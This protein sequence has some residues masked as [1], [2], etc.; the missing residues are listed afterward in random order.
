MDLFFVFF[1]FPTQCYQCD[2]VKGS[3]LPCD[4]GS[5]KGKKVISE[6]K[7]NAKLKIL[8]LQVECEDKCGLLLEERLTFNKFRSSVVSSDY[9]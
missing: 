7:K 3:D 1:I 5:N 2:G 4:G 6:Y 8:T 9:R